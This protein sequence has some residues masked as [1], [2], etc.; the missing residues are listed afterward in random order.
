MLNNKNNYI[1]LDDNLSSFGVR[2]IEIKTAS[3]SSHVPT[4]S[5]VSFFL[6]IRYFSKEASLTIQKTGGHRNHRRHLSCL[7]VPHGKKA[8]FFLYN[9]MWSAVIGH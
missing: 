6:D 1:Y 4:K 7:V 2:I 3:I 5:H 8:L 9:F